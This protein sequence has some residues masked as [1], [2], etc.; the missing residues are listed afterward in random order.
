MRPFSD[1]KVAAKF[2]NFPDEIRKRMLPL[3]ELVF[4]IAAEDPR[5]GPIEETLKWDQPSYLTSE[6]KSGSTIRLGTPNSGGYGIYTHC[7]T[8]IMSDFQS[9]FSELN[10]DGNRGVLFASDVLPPQEALR[11]LIKSALTFHLKD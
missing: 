1:P 6:T 10:Y 7:Q 9:I 3:R 4:E 5:I 8:T 2:A 11:H